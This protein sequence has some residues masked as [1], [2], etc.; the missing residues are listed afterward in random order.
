MKNKTSMIEL[1]F[2]ILRLRI[3]FK[4]HCEHKSPLLYFKRVD[5]LKFSIPSLEKEVLCR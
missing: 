1:S 2:D 4:N 3:I 5:T